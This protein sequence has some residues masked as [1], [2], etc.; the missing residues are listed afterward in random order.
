MLNNY[1]RTAFRRLW[2]DKGF[3]ALNFVGLYVSVTACLLIALLIMYEGSFDRGVGAAVSRNPRVAGEPAPGLQVYRVVNQYK[4]SEGAAYNAVTPYPLATAMR[5]AM[6]DQP[7]ISQIHWERDISVLV[8]HDRP[9]R[10]KYP[11]R[12]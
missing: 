2:K 5:V 12:R 3:F 8:G 1:L 7:Y 4:S 9:R 6:P 10:N 11:F